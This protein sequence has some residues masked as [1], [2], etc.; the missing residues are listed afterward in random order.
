VE[1]GG[2]AQFGEDV[3]DVGAGGGAGDVEGAGDLFAGVAFD[4]EVED[5]AFAGGE[6]VAGVARSGGGGGILRGGMRGLF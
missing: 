4:D 3:L 2:G 5:L 6:A 1:A